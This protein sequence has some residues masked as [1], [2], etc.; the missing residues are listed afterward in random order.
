MIVK[1]AKKI[2]S[3]VL[4]I[5]LLFQ[6]SFFVRFE[7]EAVDQYETE[8]N[9]SAATADIT[10]DDYNNYGTISSTTD[11]DWWKVTFSE[12]GS[13][14]FW[15]GNVPEGCIYFMYL[16]EGEGG[17]LLAK[18]KIMVR[19]G[20]QLIN[21]RVYAGVTYTIK[22]FEGSGCSDSPYWFRTKNYTDTRQASVYTVYDYKGNGTINFRQ[23][24]TRI[25]PHARTMG[26]NADERYNRHT[27]VLFN[28]LPTLDLAVITTHGDRGEATLGGP[29]RF[30]GNNTTYGSSDY[31]GLGLYPYDALNKVKL[32]CFE[33][34][35]SGGNSEVL[36]HLV[37]GARDRGAMCC[38]GWTESFY[39]HD[40]LLWNDTFF[41]NL[42]YGY[43][44]GEALE[45]ANLYLYD[46]A[47][48]LS[49]IVSQNYAD[50]NIYALTLA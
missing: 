48:E 9:D 2:V 42:S 15:L 13:A 36:G 4:V 26:F 37:E 24:T 14:N 31:K 21:A 38:I 30:V 10:Y 8:Y 3:V 17:M 32:L 18:S 46:Q 16:Y 20:Q 23:N 25:I 28:E 19:G 6:A 43:N 22:I 35:K 44:V 39:H 34:C 7:A 12:N 27:S 41:E 29:S 50:S 11:I 1:K 5:M 40:I 45:E 49:S 47:I 33:S